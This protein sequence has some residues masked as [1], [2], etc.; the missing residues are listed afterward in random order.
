MTEKPTQAVSAKENLLDFYWHRP[1]QIMPLTGP[2][3][4]TIYPVNGFEERPPYDKGGTDWFGC[5]WEYMET[6]G[7]PAPDCSQHVLDDICDW[8]EVVEFPDLDAWDW[9]RAA[10]LDGVDGV[11]RDESLVDVV[12]LIGLWERLHVLMG[13]EEALCA[14]LEEPEEVGAFFDAMVEHKIKLIE[15]LA[16]H[17]QPDAITF[18][19]DWGTQTGPFFSPETWRELIKP[20]QKRIIDAA[21]EHGIAFIQHSCGK[22]DDIIPDLPEIGVDVLQCM[23]INDIGAALAQTGNAMSYLVSVHSQEFF[24]DD[25]AGVLTPDGVREKVRREFREWGASGR[26]AP[27]IFPPAT[28]Y[29]EIVLEEYERVRQELA[30]AHQERS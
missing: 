15:K 23:D 30:G 21:H 14:L 13:F 12:V 2:G 29:E 3:E 17:Y 27:F 5:A 10:K 19:D 25:S 11:D 8:R 7:A 1:I 26:Y 20:R 6:A 24:S 4:A 28:W 22:Y 16:E 18:H 9:E